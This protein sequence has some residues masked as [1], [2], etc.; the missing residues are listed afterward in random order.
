MSGSIYVG[1][2]LTQV[3]LFLCPSEAS[4][5]TTNAA[6]PLAQALQL[7]LEFLQQIAFHEF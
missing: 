6:A 5:P 7:P 3:Q 4:V 1:Q 2:N